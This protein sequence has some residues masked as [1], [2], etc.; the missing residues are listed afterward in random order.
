MLLDYGYH[1][2]HFETFSYEAP[3]TD[4]EVQRQEHPS[5]AWRQPNRGSGAGSFAF[6]DP[7]VGTR[8]GEETPNV[9]SRRR[10]DAQAGKGSAEEDDI[11]TLERKSTARYTDE[12]SSTRSM[13]TVVEKMFTMGGRHQVHSLPGAERT[14]G[15][16]CTSNGSLQRASNDEPIDVKAVSRLEEHEVILR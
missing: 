9:V 11:V 8:R 5:E 16:P 15:V 2:L 6:A 1:D 13:D 14:V 3:P 7:R 10:D 12:R 4:D